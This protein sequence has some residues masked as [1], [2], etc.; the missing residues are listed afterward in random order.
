MNVTSPCMFWSEWCTIQ[1]NWFQSWL[2]QT[3]LPKTSRT[4]DSLHQ[5]WNAARAKTFLGSVLLHIGG[6]SCVRSGYGNIFYRQHC[7]N[8]SDPRITILAKLKK[9][10]TEQNESSTVLELYAVV[11]KLCHTENTQV[12]SWLT[13]SIRKSHLMPWSWCVKLQWNRVCY[14]TSSLLGAMQTSYLGK[15]TKPQWNCWIPCHQC[16]VWWRHR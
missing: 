6:H 8:F 9:A 5:F 12:H 4:E 14:Q 1:H 11:R 13:C 10:N 3:Y 15:N 16:H 2:W 7:S